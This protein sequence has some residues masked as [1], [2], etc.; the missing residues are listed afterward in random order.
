MLIS[1]YGQIADTFHDEHQQPL[2]LIGRLQ[3]AVSRMPVVQSQYWGTNVL[4]LYQAQIADS[5]PDGFDYVLLCN[6]D[7]YTLPLPA[8]TQLIARTRRFAL[9]K[10]LR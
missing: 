8:D 4:P 1:Q 7:R 6:A 9:L 2:R 10:T 5:G 3:A